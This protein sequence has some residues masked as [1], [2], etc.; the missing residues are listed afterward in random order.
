M[1]YVFD[2]ALTKPEENIYVNL[3]ERMSL[4]PYESFEKM[5]ERLFI[6]LHSYKEGLC[7]SKD[8]LDT[9]EPLAVS[10]SLTGSVLQWVERGSVE[11]RRVERVH[12]HSPNA[13]LSLYF[14]CEEEVFRFCHELRGSRTNWIQDIEFF[15]FTPGDFALIGDP[16]DRRHKLEATLIDP[17]FHISSNRGEMSVAVDQFDMWERYQSSLLL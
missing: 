8:P 11:K 3:T 13:K 2:I 1:Q 15:K 7:L 10:R 16:S 9:K 5:W 12:N 14:D 17:V 4:H 6:Y